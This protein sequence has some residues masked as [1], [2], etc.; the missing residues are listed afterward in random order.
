MEKCWNV[1]DANIL[2]QQ[3]QAFKQ[4]F[5]ALRAL[6]G[7]A[8]V[9]RLERMREG[10]CDYLRNFFKKRRIAASH[11]LVIM[12]SDESRAVKPYAIPLQYI[13]YRSLRDQYI[14][15][16]TASIKQDLTALGI[17]VVGKGK[18]HSV[19]TLPMQI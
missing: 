2:I 4:R 3:A 19:I 5:T 11:V 14:Q 13:P 15:D 16:F 6:I 1:A 12:A 7:D 17:L 10:F 8:R 9:E 18:L